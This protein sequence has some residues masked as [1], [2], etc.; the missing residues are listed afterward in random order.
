MI[1]K[2]NHIKFTW[3]QVKMILKLPQEMTNYSC[4]WTPTNQTALANLCPFL[5]LT[6]GTFYSATPEW[7]NGFFFLTQDLNGNQFGQVDT[8]ANDHVAIDIKPSPQPPG[9]PHGR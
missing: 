2:F 1:K 8:A 6:S 3:R 9:N 7:P 4:W 5:N